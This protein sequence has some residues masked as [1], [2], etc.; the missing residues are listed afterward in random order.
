MIHK[1]LVSGLCFTLLVMNAHENLIDSIIVHENRVDITPN[2]S[3]KEAYLLDN[4]FIEYD[5]EID[6]TKID[7]SLVVMP[8]VC[9]VMSIV[10]ASDTTYYVDS[11]D[12]ELYHSLKNIKQIIKTL[13]PKT[14]WNGRL[15]PRK[16]VK[17]TIS[18][19]KNPQTDIAMLFSG[20]LD[21]TCSS[22]YESN[23]K[24]LLITAWGQWD[25]PLEDKQL[26]KQ[27]RSQIIDFAQSHNHTNAFLKSNY[28][29]FINYDAVEALASDV[30]HWR[31]ETIE[32]LGWAGLT[33]PILYAKGYK[34][35]YIASSETWDLQYPSLALPYI[36]N[37]LFFGTIHIQQ[38]LF[39]MTRMQKIEWLV[40]YAHSNSLRGY[41]VKGCHRQAPTNCCN[42]ERCIQTICGLLLLGENIR[43]YDY[44]IPYKEALKNIKTLAK[45]DSLDY[46][47]IYNFMCMAEHIKEDIA[48]SEP[49]PN[50]LLWLMEIPFDL[51]TAKDIK[52]QEKIDWE[53]L[54][55]MYPHIKNVA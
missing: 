44:D 8:F 49:I 26:W 29:S 50:S 45:K 48:K 37:L 40:Q 31:I 11:L 36:D 43:D 9:Q 15:I 12:Y 41:K 4:F 14:K 10:W 7:L 42:C 23:K 34:E 35:L 21:S 22:L 30:N 33:A 13:Y 51:S 55:R 27:R 18:D 6:L 3:F 53:A 24:Q 32:G 47:V 39:G 54:H 38:H 5:K 25:V 17:N 20:G 28:V 46:E 52:G 16:L 2:K 1:T 19:Q